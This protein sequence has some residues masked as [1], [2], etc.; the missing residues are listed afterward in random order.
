MHDHDETEILSSVGERFLHHLE[1]P[2]HPGALEPADGRARGVG[3]CGDAIELFIR[4][5]DGCIREIGHEPRG[6]LYT[7]ACASAV[8]FLA[9]GKHLEQAARLLPEDVATELGGLPDDHMHCAALAVNTL[10]E[11]IE[12]H[13][14]RSRNLRVSGQ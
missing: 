1:F 8:S 10:N 9:A 13:L 3:T 12:D 7:A 14:H 5:S 2:F 11:A 4:V 6:C